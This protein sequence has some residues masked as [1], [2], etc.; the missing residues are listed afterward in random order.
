MDALR[1]D[2]ET[3]DRRLRG[4]EYELRAVRG[5]LVKIDANVADLRQ[6]VQGTPTCRLEVLQAGPSKSCPQPPRRS[7]RVRKTKIV[8]TPSGK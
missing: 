1:D 8:F 6:T 5:R 4:L 2:P 7:R 3:G